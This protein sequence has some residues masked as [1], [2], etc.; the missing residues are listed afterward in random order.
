MSKFIKKVSCIR[1]LILCQL[2]LLSSL[3][4]PLFVQHWIMSMYHSIVGVVILG[5]RN[6]CQNMY[7]TL[8]LLNVRVAWLV[9][10]LAPFEVLQDGI[11]VHIKVLLLPL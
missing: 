8:G 5:D 10:C 6:L 7:T 9:C 1:Y 3:Y 2:H 4:I 11:L